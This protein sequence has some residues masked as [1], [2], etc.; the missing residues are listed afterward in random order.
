MRLQSYDNFIISQR[1]NRIFILYF[2]QLALPFNKVGCVSEIKIKV[3]KHLSLSPWF[4][5]TCVS[6]HCPFHMVTDVLKMALR[7]H[8]HSASWWKI[9]CFFIAFFAFLRCFFVIMQGKGYKTYGK[10]WIIKEL[11]NNKPRCSSSI[12]IAVGTVVPQLV[13]RVFHSYGT[14]VTPVMVHSCYKPFLWPVSFLNESV[15]VCT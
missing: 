14:V 9:W 2:A 1:K 12:R 13:S 4:L 5:I 11:W 15:T 8:R 6:R 7:P 3:L 10:L